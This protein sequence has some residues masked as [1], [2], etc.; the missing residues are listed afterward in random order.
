MTANLWHTTTVTTTD[1]AETRSGSSGYGLGQSYMENPDNPLDDAWY[2]A[3]IGGVS[4]SSGIR[5]VNQSMLRIPAFWQGVELLSSDVAKIPAL[6]CTGDPDEQKQAVNHPAFKLIHDQAN[7]EQSAFEF[8]RMM[9]ACRLIWNNS[10]AWIQRDGMGNPTGLYP[11]LPDRTGCERLDDGRLIYQSQINNRLA[12]FDSYDILH[13]RGICIDRDRDACNIIWYM[14]NAIGKILAREDFASRFYQRGGRL[15]GILTLPHESKKVQRDKVEAGF[16]KSYEGPD[17]AFKVV[18]LREGA[19]FDTAQSTFRETQMIEAEAADVKTVARILNI[20]PHKLGDDSKSA[21]NSLE[22]ENRSYLESSLSN[23]LASR[24]SECRLKLLSLRQKMRRTHYIQDDVS[25][26]LRT[27]AKSK[28]EIA[29]KGVTGG[30]MTKNEARKMNG[31]PPVEGGDKLLNPSGM[32]PQDDDK[33]TE[34]D[35]DT[36]DESNIDEEE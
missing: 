1:V 23:H 20:P 7:E 29:S 35:I 6:V 25:E 2:D 24:R 4:S 18:V 27:D 32:L 5:V 36:D 16:R 28:A 3:Y 19:K 8:W 21:H 22:S 9:L 30:W 15:G 26:F 14:R 33:K 31:L 34:T 10:Y 11:L 17:N 12:Y 13:L